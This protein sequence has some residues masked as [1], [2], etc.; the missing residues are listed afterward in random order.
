MAP[1]TSHPHDRGRA[2]HL[3]HIHHLP[4][5]GAHAVVQEGRKGDGLIPQ[6]AHGHRHG[7]AGFDLL[8]AARA[9]IPMGRVLGRLGRQV[10]RDVFDDACPRAA[11]PLEFAA[12]RRAGRQLV[13]YAVVDPLG[14]G[15]G[16]RV[17][18]SHRASCVAWSAVS[19]QRVRGCWTGRGAR[20]CGRWPRRVRAVAVGSP[21]DRVRR[22]H[23]SAPRSECR[24]GRPERNSDRVLTHHWFTPTRTSRESPVQPAEGL[25]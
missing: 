17:R 14:A 15:S 10:R 8:V 23:R 2:N 11:G 13:F 25:P 21:A 6:R 7:H 16:L 5:R 18:A 19:S 12:A 22:T 1:A 24:C 20:S 4:G 3:K 9:P